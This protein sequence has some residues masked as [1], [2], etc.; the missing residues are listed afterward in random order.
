VVKVDGAPAPLALFFDPKGQLTAEAS[1]P[2][3][4]TL[5]LSDGSKR[6]LVIEES[7]ETLAFEGAWTS[8]NADDKGFSVNQQTSFDL[9]ATFGKG[10]QVTL[11]LGEVSVMAKVTLNGK[12]YDTLWR[13]PYTLDVTDAL[14]PGTNQL[15]VLV[16]STSA[17]K[18]A[19]GKVALRTSKRVI[20]K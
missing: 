4:T 20:V 7:A 15:R 9:P 18:P 16:T 12:A 11:D 3:N 5:T 8:A 10:K 1:G 17:G 6:N 2:I 14:K 13:S 19:L